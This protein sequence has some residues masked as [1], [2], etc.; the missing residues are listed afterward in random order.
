MGQLGFQDVW[1]GDQ[2]KVPRT[3]CVSVI[4]GPKS[5]IYDSA[6]RRILAVTEVYVMV[7]H[8][9]IEDTQENI[10]AAMALAEETEKVLHGDA[11]MG[12]LAI[13]SLVTANDPGYVTRGGNQMSVSRLTFQ[14]TSKAI[15]PSMFNS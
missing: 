1:L 12:G 4:P 6:P 3:P 7:Y 14:V 8:D 9:R 15:L 2:A 10:R 5:Q 11:Q 13:A